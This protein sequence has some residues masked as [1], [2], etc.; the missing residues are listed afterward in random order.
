MLKEEVL[1]HKKISELY[2]SGFTFIHPDH[3]Y[4]S[5]P[6]VTF[7]KLIHTKTIHLWVMASTH[8]LYFTFREYIH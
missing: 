1:H 8:S 3:K 7:L 5:H 4:M 6:L 2:T